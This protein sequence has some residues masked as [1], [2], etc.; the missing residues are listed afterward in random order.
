MKV[1]FDIGGTTARAG[2]IDASGAVEATARGEVRGAT[3]PGD[4]ADL[5]AG[6]LEELAAETALEPEALDGLGVAIAG[7]LTADRRTVRNSPNLGWRGVD[8]AELLEAELDWKGTGKR[9]RLCNDVDASLWGECVAGVVEGVDDVLAVSVGTGVGGAAVVDGNLVRG[10]DGVAGEIGHSKVEMG[11]RLCGCGERG[12]VEAYAG[13]V[14][15]ERR[16]DERAGEDLEQIRVD[17]GIDMA[18]ADRM[19]DDN[20]TVDR[21][22]RDATDKL[23]MVVGNACTLLNPRVLLLGGGVIARG[24][25]YRARLLSKIPSVVLAVALDELEI[26]RPALGDRAGLV[27]A[28]HLEA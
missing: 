19:A 22:W 17:G 8:F 4:V 14:H 18:A 11:G 10:A 3:A 27:G 26:R 1:G 15:L 16:L 23:A 20:P 28:A 24:E 6:L 7:Q 25:T 13:G 12:C 9:V 21:I 2:V 5:A